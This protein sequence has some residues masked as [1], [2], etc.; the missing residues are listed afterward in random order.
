MLGI[1]G[2]H[3]SQHPPENPREFEPSAH[4]QHIAD[5]FAEAF[6]N[7]EGNRGG[8]FHGVIRAFLKVGKDAAAVDLVE[9]KDLG[10][11]EPHVKNVPD[12][13]N[14]LYVLLRELLHEC[15]PETREKVV[16]RERQG[17]HVE[18]NLIFGILNS[19][20]CC[21]ECTI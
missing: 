2:R 19:V 4:V 18:Q 17:G 15:R 14:V 3:S 6:A 5:A 11:P 20:E 9:I 21:R 7:G 12:K 16:E 1:L 10:Q 13:T 8:Q